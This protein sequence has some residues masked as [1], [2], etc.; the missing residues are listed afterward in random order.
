MS[1]LY[2]VTDRHDR[3][4][5]FHGGLGSRS[6]QGSYRVARRRGGVVKDEIEIYRTLVQ[7]ATVDE[8]TQL[9]GR[10]RGHLNRLEEASFENEFVQVELGRQLV[11]NYEL[12]VSDA[13]L[14]DDR[15]RACLYGAIAYFLLSDDVED[16][17]SSPIGLEDDALVFNQAC[18][19]IGR[20][21]L[22]VE[23]I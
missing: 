20:S 2:L 9:M 12:L 17:L 21:D 4:H 18:A 3:Q 14:L 16:D 8:L 15:Q 10:V 7:P 19:E 22:V 13:A 5:H 23:L 11:R 6:V 1:A